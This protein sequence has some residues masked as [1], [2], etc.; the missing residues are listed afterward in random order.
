MA[1]PTYH[2]HLVN[3]QA[4]TTTRCNYFLT[5]VCGWSLLLAS[6]SDVRAA[7]AALEHV[8]ASRVASVDELYVRLGGVQ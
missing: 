4:G 2:K 1:E 3:V 7:T 8:Q 5:C 6:R